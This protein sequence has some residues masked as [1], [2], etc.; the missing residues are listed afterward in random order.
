VDNLEVMFTR[1]NLPEADNEGCFKDYDLSNYEAVETI[2]RRKT[3]L[4]KGPIGG[5]QLAMF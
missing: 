4:A 2:S 1:Y 3:I 5:K